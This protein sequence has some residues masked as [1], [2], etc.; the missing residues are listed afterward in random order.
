MDTDDQVRR[1]VRAQL[2]SDERIPYVDEIAVDV[3]GGEVTL[4]GTVGSF[5]QRRAAVADAR[6]T[7]GVFD[8]FDDLEV[9]LLNQDRRGDAEIR[10]AALQRLLWDPDLPGD[11]LDV[12]VRNGWVRLTGEVE[13]Q[14]QSDAAFSH[15]ASLAGVTGVTNEIK[16]IQALSP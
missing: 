2:E 13:Y 8:V 1:D 4:R 12:E 16:V 5:P 15:V 7:R 3:H 9:R 14:F 6:R 10:G 11:Y